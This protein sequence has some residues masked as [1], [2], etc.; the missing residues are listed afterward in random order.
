MKKRICTLLLLL[1]VFS[2]CCGGAALA[3]DTT[4]TALGYVTDSADILTAEQEAS[5]SSYAAQLSE[6]LNC[7]LY[8]VTVQDYRQYTNGN[9]NN[10][11]T[12]L[13][14]YYDLGAG[15]D[16]DGLLLLLSMQDR[17]YSIIT[18]GYYGN[19]CFGDRNL[20]L[21]EEAFLDNFRYD[22]WM[23]GFEDYLNVAGDI[24]RT[25]QAHGLTLDKEDQVFPGI[26]YPG[27][28]YKYGVSG[29]LPVP[30]RLL[31][32]LGVPCII[33]LIVCS[34]F[35]SQMKTARERTTA[36]EYVVPGSA[37]LRLEEDRFVNRTESRVPIQT[38]SSS[39]GRGGSFGGGGGGGFSGHSGKF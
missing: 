39:S 23:G 34:S 30:I 32:G 29:K 19:Y 3:Q 26:A 35:K 5:L 37:T 21:I 25:A 15:P 14:T 36:E 4:N 27:N 9:V 2:L 17:D 24:L 33:A 20:T 8:I 12:E 13:Y 10:C 31:I 18:H 38:Q 6:S 22:D 16:R 7:K 1:L 28:S 11:A